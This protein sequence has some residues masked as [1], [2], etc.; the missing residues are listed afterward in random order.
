MSEFLFN[1]P[2]Q[3]VITGHQWIIQF[4][5]EACRPLI[6]ICFPLMINFCSPCLFLCLLL[7]SVFHLSVC[8]PLCKHVACI[9]GLLC[10]C[11]GD[12]ASASHGC[13]RAPVTWFRLR[14]IRPVWMNNEEC[15][16]LQN[17]PAS[18]PLPRARSSRS[19]LGH[20]GPPELGQWG[21]RA[22]GWRGTQRGFREKPE[23]FLWR[24]TRLCLQRNR[25]RSTNICV[26]VNYCIIWQI[27]PSPLS[28]T[29]VFCV[30]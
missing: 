9:I 8:A 1:I 26:F 6:S 3:T 12:N 7:S 30:I 27:E 13:G 5:F 28:Q 22:E 24:A 19:K 14:Y 16:S 25:A 2:P 17:I 29:S 10:D 11:G 21:E 23:L 20:A 15:L 18:L 4:C